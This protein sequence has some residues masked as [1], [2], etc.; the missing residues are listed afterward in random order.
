[1]LVL[2]LP[3]PKGNTILIIASYS[4]LGSPEIANYLTKPETCSQ[5]ARLFEERF[6]STPQYFEIL[7]HVIGIDKTAYDTEI[8]IF[9]EIRSN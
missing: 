2:K 3:G 8:L 6:Q 4:S 1:V 5:L 7:F 9:N